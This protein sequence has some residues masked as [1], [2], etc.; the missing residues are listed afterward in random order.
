MDYF[1]VA[2]IVEFN[3]AKEFKEAKENKLPNIWFSKKNKLKA[4][5]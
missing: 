4:P 2:E 5:L 1:D 3:Y